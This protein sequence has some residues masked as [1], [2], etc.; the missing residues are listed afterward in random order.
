MENVERREELQKGEGKL[1]GR[2]LRCRSRGDKGRNAAL[3]T[4][5]ES[6]G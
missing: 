1:G 2:G 4:E 5:R 3:G 6:G